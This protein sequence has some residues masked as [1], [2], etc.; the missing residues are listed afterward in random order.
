MSEA[1]PPL[2]DK[3]REEFGVWMRGWPLAAALARL[4]YLEAE[5]KRL[6]EALRYMADSDAPGI[7]SRREPPVEDLEP[8]PSEWIEES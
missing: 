6:R 8:P 7:G 2:T 3:Q 5:V 1:P 4:D